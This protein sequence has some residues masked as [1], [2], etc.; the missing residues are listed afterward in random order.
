MRGACVTQRVSGHPITQPLGQGL[1]GADGEGYAIVPKGSTYSPPHNTD[2]IETDRSRRLFGGLFW[3][4]H[5]A[6]PRL[7]ILTERSVCRA[8]FCNK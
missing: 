2:R 5:D 8:L 6:H 1:G 7:Q 4:G 3:P